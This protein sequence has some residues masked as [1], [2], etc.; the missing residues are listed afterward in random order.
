MRTVSRTDRR[1]HV[2]DHGMYAIVDDI[3]LNRSLAQ[4]WFSK[5]GANVVMASTGKELVDK[6]IPTI[7]E[8]GSS[9]F[10]AILTDVNMPIMSGDDATRV[11]RSRGYKGVIIGLTGSGTDK[12]RK[13]YM[14]AGMTT[15]MVKPF[16]F[17]QLAEIIIEKLEGKE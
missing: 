6:V 12:E 15:V 9:S 3:Q 4:K 7:N 11:L 10:D 5:A 8:D 2:Y 16:R 13:S 14:D 17:D 1:R